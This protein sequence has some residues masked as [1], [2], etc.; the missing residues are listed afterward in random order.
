MIL[1]LRNVEIKFLLVK[2]AY[3]KDVREARWTMGCVVL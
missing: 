1:R 3:S 2:D